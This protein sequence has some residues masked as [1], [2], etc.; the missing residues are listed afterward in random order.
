MNDRVYYRANFSNIT[1]PISGGARQ[2]DEEGNEYASIPIQLPSNL[3]PHNTQ[4]RQVEMML[5][6][7][8]VPLSKI[9]IAHVP[10]KNITEGGRIRI[11]TKG[12]MTCWPFR[13]DGYGTI[14]PNTYSGPMYNYLRGNQW[15][16][17]DMLLQLNGQQKSF[18]YDAKLQKM[19]RTMD[20]GFENIDA[21]C[22]FFTSNLQSCLNGA[23]HEANSALFPSDMH[24]PELICRGDNLVLEYTNRGSQYTVVPVHNEIFTTSMSLNEPTRMWVRTVNASGVQTA[25]YEQPEYVSGFSIVVNQCIKDLFPELPWRK[26]DNRLLPEFTVVGGVASGKSI[27]TWQSKNDGD[28]FFYV[29]DTVKAD[30][31]VKDDTIRT[32]TSLDPSDNNSMLSASAEYI[33]RGVNVLSTI[34]I[35]SFIVVLD[36]ISLTQ[37]TFPVDISPENTSSAQLSTIPII[38]NYYPVWNTISDLSTNMIIVKDAF[39]NAAPIILDRS[40]MYERNMRFSIY[41]I[42]KQ[43]KMH[44]LTI[45]PNSVLSIQICYSFIY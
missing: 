8:D 5:T 30:L 34:N 31:H 32:C 2:L 25:H 11:I 19:K 12:L 7:L 28:P 45:D 38:E 24:Y 17:Q 23:L 29:L 36:G 27:P 10:I 33:F 9:P 1:A 43:G 6:K 22:E 35:S 3:F 40:A 21:L 39:T 20:F 44:L 14:R 26:V 18:D 37:Q 41:Y 16:I 4:P 13:F 42:T 15:R